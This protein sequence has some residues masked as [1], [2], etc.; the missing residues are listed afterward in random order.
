M[1]LGVVMRCCSDFGMKSK[2]AARNQTSE[3]VRAWRARVHVSGMK[4]TVAVWMVLTIV[5]L[6]E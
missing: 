1:A 4:V 6:S 3:D 2:K 5:L